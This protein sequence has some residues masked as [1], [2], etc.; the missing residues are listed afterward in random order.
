ML[1]Y[2]D[3][4]REV[5]SRGRTAGTCI[6]R[7]PAFPSKKGGFPFQ[8]S[9]KTGQEVRKGSEPPVPRGRQADL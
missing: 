2:G 8:Q 6:C 7:A 9:W 1:N 3:G 5:G 4:S